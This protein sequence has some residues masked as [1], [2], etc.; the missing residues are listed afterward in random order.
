MHDFRRLFLTAACWN[1]VIALGTFAAPTVVYG[2]AMPIPAPDNLAMTQLFMGLVAV[3]GLGYFWAS[4]DLV[5][6]VAVV[7]LGAVGKSTVF[8]LAAL[9]LTQGKIG[10]LLMAIALG[11]LIFALLFVSVLRTLTRDA[12]REG[13]IG[14]SHAS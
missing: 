7:R 5:A 13:P 11:D 2:F 8:V 1:W 10:W 12:H 6:N 14:E 3:F 9:L 4:R